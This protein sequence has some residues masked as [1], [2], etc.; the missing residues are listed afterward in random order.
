MKKGI[1]LTGP[2][3]VSFTEE[4]SGE[5]YQV[6]ANVESGAIQVTKD[7]EDAIEDVVEVIDTLKFTAGEVFTFAASFYYE[8]VR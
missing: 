1:V 7:G 2:T 4:V 3:T 6:T 5:E 8:N